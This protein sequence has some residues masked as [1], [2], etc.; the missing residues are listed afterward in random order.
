MPLPLLLLACVPDHGAFVAR[1]DAAAAAFAGTPIAASG[2]VLAAADGT[3]VA[4]ATVTLHGLVAVTDADGRWAIAGLPRK[5]ALAVLAAEAWRTERVPVHLA[6]PVAEAEVAVPALPLVPDAGVRFVFAGDTSLGRRYLDPDESTPADEVPPDDPDAL[7]Q[8]SD[9]LPGSRAVFDPVRELVSGADLFLLNFESVVTDD[10]ATPHPD[11]DYRIFSLPGSL[12]ALTELGVGYVSL[13]N[14]HTYDYLERGVVDTLTHVGVAGLPHSG[15]GRDEVEAFVPAV[16]DEDAVT[17][18]IVAANSVSGFQYATDFQADATSGGAADLDDDARVADTLAAAR[19]AGHVPLAFL[20][21]GVEYAEAPN[22]VALDRFDRVAADGAALIVASHPHVPQGFGW[23]GDVLAAWSL[24]NFTFDQDRLE[25]L[26]GAV[27]FADL[28]AGAPTAVRTRPVYLEGYV[29][30][31]LAG[32]LGDRLARRMARD[33]TATVVPWGGEAWVALDD[34]VVETRR[35]VTL[36]VTV[37]EAGVLVDL[38]GLAGAHEWLVAARV[39]GAGV[40]GRPGEDRL[41]FGE[42]EDP[43]ADDA[44]VEGA[45]WVLGDAAAL[46]LSGARRGAFGL[47]STRGAWNVDASAWSFANRVRFPGFAEGAPIKDV[48]LLAWARGEDAGALEVDVEYQPSEGDVVFATEALALADGGTFDWRLVYADLDVPPDL[49]DPTDV[50]A[51]PRAVHL[52]F[53]HEPPARGAGW[54]A[55]DDV[56]L[57][58]W[59]EPVDLGAGWAS[60]VPN[61]VEFLRLEGDA[62]VTLTLTFASWTPA[63]W[64]SSE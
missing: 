4:G 10:P 61:V 3:P 60:D 44:T 46:C 54:L 11:K 34:A 2:R 33:S 15:L 40:A 26:L 48:T 5:N 27:L 47:C 52:A 38:R 22:D 50:E 19:A 59:G 53:R 37:G 36:P 56:A 58:A 24:G 42:F 20:H 9:P 55:L 23:H 41:V 13:G 63:A 32:P 25:T 57:V 7:V 14:N 64:A 1:E 45:R 31:P 12:P 21:T 51:N 17:Y 35:E 43:D 18:A 6:R 49:A 62:T 39:D 16:L 30:R 29:P 28:D 8:A